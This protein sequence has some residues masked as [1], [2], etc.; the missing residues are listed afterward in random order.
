[1]LSLATKI[2]NFLV[3]EDPLDGR[4]GHQRLVPSVYIRELLLKVETVAKE[5]ANSIFVV[6][7]KSEIRKGA[8]PAD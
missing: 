8:F 5:I 7:N 2:L 3:V 1:M 4:T 6:L